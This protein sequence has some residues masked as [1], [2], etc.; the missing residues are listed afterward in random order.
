MT[1]QNHKPGRPFTA[2]AIAIA[3]V[4]LL[5]LVS[6]SDLTGNFIKDYNL[7]ADVMPPDSAAIATAESAEIIDPELL[8]AMENAVNDTLAAVLAETEPADSA[9][10]LATEADIRP[11]EELARVDGEMAIEDY[12]AGA[13]GL[14]RLK[15]A[16]ESG[17][18]ARIA[19]IGDSYIEGDIFAKDVRQQ[20]QELYGGKGVGYVPPY[21]PIAGFRR[22]VSV[23]GSQAWQQHT[24]SNGKRKHFN[25]SGEYYTAEGPASVTYK[26]Y[27]KTTPQLESW[28]QSKVVFI[29]PSA[30]TLTLITDSDTLSVDVQPSAEPQEALLSGPTKKFTVR[31]AVPGIVFLGA[32]LD[33]EAGVSLDC[34]S[35]RG[36][37][38]IT[39]GN[40]SEELAALLRRHIDYDL[41]IVEYGINALSA[42]Q[43]DYRAYARM[44]V[45]VVKKLRA[46]YPNADILMLGVGDRG[47]KSGTEV[48]SIGPIAN[49]VSSQRW[50]AQTAQC[51]FWDTR[52]AMGGA[53]A[54]VSWRERG[55]ANGD[56]IH[57]NSDGGRELA[58]LLVKSMLKK[59]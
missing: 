35:M 25:I 30:G 52:E 16:L 24:L 14:G 42:T 20:L 55:L 46:C 22:T 9:P 37:S 57:L 23:N 58:T 36:D 4:A 32:W 10:A 56:Y 41:I 13:T 8:K 39:H 17:R 12:T 50:A 59:L 34:M 21:S 1:D 3:A 45:G 51:L 7:L 38:G 53:D 44:M 49:M 11:S 40:L 15:A 31:S 54:I 19:M 29:A 5:S 43:T 27:K 2:V 28:S 26:S 48:H 6:W 33:G 47:Q 18:L